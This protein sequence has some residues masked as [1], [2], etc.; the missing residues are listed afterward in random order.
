MRTHVREVPNFGRRKGSDRVAKQDPTS[1]SRAQEAL[2]E[3]ALARA[4]R[5]AQAQREAAPREPDPRD[6]VFSGT[7]PVPGA[8]AA[9]TRAPKRSGRSTRKLSPFTVVVGL[10]LMAIASVL[11]ISNVIAV[12][13]LAAEIGNLEEQ[14]QSIL[15]EQEMLRA[16]IARLSGL[17]RIRRIAEDEYGMQYSDAVPGWLSVDPERVAE[18]QRLSE[19]AGTQAHP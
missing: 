2:L 18:L 13:S 9:N 3:Q 8:P 19:M 16:Q 1:S 6:R 15:N 17:E 14:Y 10:L 5:R 7:M 4:S 12:S 11:Y